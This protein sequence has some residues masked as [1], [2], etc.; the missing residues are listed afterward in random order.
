MT[1]RNHER[2]GERWVTTVSKWARDVPDPARH[3]DWDLTQ[4]RNCCR[5]PNALI[6]VKP[7]DIPEYQWKNTRVVAARLNAYGILAI[8][9]R[10]E[11][12]KIQIRVAEPDG[13]IRPL[14]TCDHD[15]F[16]E[17][18]TW[19]NAHHRCSPLAVSQ[20]RLLALLHEVRFTLYWVRRSRNSCGKS[21]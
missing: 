10:G 11:T 2:S 13:N 1:A 15:E 18:M 9:P 7:W 12:D 3:Q 14:K 16:V 19:I 4:Y 6:E 17:V 20:G 21:S 8:E 5:I